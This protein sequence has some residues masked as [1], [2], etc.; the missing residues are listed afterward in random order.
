MSG[1]SLPLLSWP[2]L[3]Q[4]TR[5]LRRFVESNVIVKTLFRFVW[6]AVAFCIAIA[7]A[8]AAL[9]ALGAL[10]VGDELR[11]AAP[12]DPMLRHGA[13]PI[14]GIVLFTSTVTPALTALPALV[15]AVVGEVLRI[16]SWMY[17]VLA[18]GSSSRVT[19]TTSRRCRQVLTLPSSPPRAL[20]VASS[21]GCS[22]APGLEAPRALASS[23]GRHLR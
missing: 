17:Y 16:R 4:A 21:I 5:A 22:R 8:L 19:P 2:G 7:V 3:T 9:F 14:F 10:W 15:A 20:P 11:A 13:A 6:V 23:T 1:Q 18:G 12:H